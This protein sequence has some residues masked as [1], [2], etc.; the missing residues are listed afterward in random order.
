MFPTVYRVIE[1]ALFTFIGGNEIE[2][3]FVVTK[4]IKTKLCKNMFVMAS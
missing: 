4:I 3:A 1:L 2:H